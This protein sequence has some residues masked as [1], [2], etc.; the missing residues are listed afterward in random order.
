RRPFTLTEEIPIRIQLLELADDYFV[1]LLTLHHIAIDLWSI[2]LLVHEVVTI[3]RAYQ[4]DQ[5]PDL[6]ELR[7][8]YSDYAAWQQRW[9]TEH[10]DQQLAYWQQTLAPDPA[11]LMLPTDKP[12]P[13]EQT[14]AGADFAFQLPDTLSQQVFQFGH[15]EKATLFMVLLAAYHALLF[16]YTGQSEINVGAPIANRHH[17]YTENLLGFFVNTVVINASLT[18][19]MSFRQLLRQ[20]RQRALGA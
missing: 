16:R 10:Q 7:M 11:P 8:Q 13:A 14:D 6:P 5:A 1:L 3:Y 18:P 2:E 12:R 9:L 4:E 17:M 20:V 19:E 15:Q